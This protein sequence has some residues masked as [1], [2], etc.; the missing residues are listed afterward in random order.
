[1][2]ETNC[3]GLS[4]RAWAGGEDA[5]SASV[6]F[7]PMA[8]RSAIKSHRRALDMQRAN[9]TTGASRVRR[10][11]LPGRDPG[12]GQ[13]RTLTLLA[14]A[15]RARARRVACRAGIA[16]SVVGKVWACGRQVDL[17]A[18]RPKM[19]DSMR[20]VEGG[21]VDSFRQHARQ[22]MANPSAVSGRG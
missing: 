12:Q 16:H 22:Q 19:D 6:A 10:A 15:R 5:R 21:W 3:Q 9:L 14:K 4:S 8:A 7:G 1:M 18:H 11:E 20:E 13:R 17:L 2:T